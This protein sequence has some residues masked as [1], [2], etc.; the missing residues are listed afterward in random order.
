MNRR[1]SATSNGPP[2]VIKSQPVLKPTASRGASARLRPIDLASLRRELKREVQRRQDLQKSLASSQRHY[3]EL[4]KRSARMEEHLR[5]LSHEILSAQEEERKRISREL[6]DEIGQILTAVNVKLAALRVESANN[7][8]GIETKIAVTQRLVERSMNSVHQ[9]ARQLRPP[10]LDDLGLI[11]ALR[12]SMKEFTKRTRVR[13][14]FTAFAAVERLSSDKRTVLFRVVQEALTNVAKH[15]RARAVRVSI[16]K[17]RGTVRMEIHD[18]GRSFS[19]ERELAAVR[20]HGLGLLGMR[21]RVEMVGGSFV[22]E[23]APGSG[24]IVRAEI[25]FGESRRRPTRAPKR[26][27]S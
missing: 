3:D 2:A 24:T 10:L 5:R 8:T 22:V 19:V 12:S 13:I 14:Q 23:S 6:H 17:L 1:F 4:L 18:D 11:P 16:V 26:G 15:A 20:I 21:E 7:T 9:F 25:P 27:R